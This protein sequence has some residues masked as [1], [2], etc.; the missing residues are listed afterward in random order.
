[1][2]APNGTRQQPLAATG[3]QIVSLMPSDTANSDAR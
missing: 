3:A 2:H 1:M